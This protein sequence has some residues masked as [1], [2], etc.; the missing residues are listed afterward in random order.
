MLTRH[1]PNC[2]VEH[3]G[4]PSHRLHGRNRAAGECGYGTLVMTLDNEWIDCPMADEH[5]LSGVV[6][7]CYNHPGRE[8]LCSKEYSAW[9]YAN[10][11]WTRG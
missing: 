2:Y 9:M 4:P 7:V 6:L 11:V 3:G 5:N 1:D 8:P 10:G